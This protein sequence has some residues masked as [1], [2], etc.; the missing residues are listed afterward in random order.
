[1]SENVETHY[2]SDLICTKCYAIGAPELEHIGTWPAFLFRWV[3][4]GAI[5]IPPS[6]AY[7]AIIFAFFAIAKG[8]LVAIDTIDLFPLFKY[9]PQTPY[10]L[11]ICK[12]CKGVNKLVPIKCT[13]GQ[14]ALYWHNKMHLSERKPAAP[15]TE[16]EHD[17][18]DPEILEQISKASTETEF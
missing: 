18:D 3:V 5:I 15:I 13:E 17:L 7:F 12:S 4:V 2:H 1:M 11:K 9:L 14:S 10:T 8:R 6:I 16:P